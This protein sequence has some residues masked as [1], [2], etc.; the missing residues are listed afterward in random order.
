MEAIIAH[1]LCADP[2]QVYADDLEAIAIAEA[3]AAE[4]ARLEAE[5]QARLEAEQN[6]GGQ[7][8]GSGKVTNG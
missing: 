6:A 1:Q 8:G 2:A 5:E 7:S 3:D 4:K